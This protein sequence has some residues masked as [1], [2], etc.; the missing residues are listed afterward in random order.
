MGRTIA[1]LLAVLLFAGGSGAAGYIAWQID[2]EVKATPPIAAEL[3]V[4][5]PEKHKPKTAAAGGHGAPAAEASKDGHGAAA[6]AE[7]GHGA[8]A[9]AAANPPS[10][11]LSIDEVYANIPGEGQRNHSFALKVELE[12]FDESNRS[13]IEERSSVVRSTILDAVRQNDYRGLS[14]LS[15]KLYFKEVLVSRINEALGGPAV[16]DV[17]FS[18]FYLQ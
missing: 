17:H 7:G 9:A 14:S 6:P 2:K 8:P 3:L 1:R 12:L 13:V 16:R 18:S 11:I 4:P 10:P 15:G 5:I